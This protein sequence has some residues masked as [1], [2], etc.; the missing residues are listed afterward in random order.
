MIFGMVVIMRN[1]IRSM[2]RSV[3]AFAIQGLVVSMGACPDFW[4]VSQKLYRK[5]SWKLYEKV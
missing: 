5:V 3:M 4:K 1:K 2:A